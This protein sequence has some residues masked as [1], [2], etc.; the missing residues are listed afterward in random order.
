MH[1]SCT[2]NY[3][4]DIKSRENEYCPDDCSNGGDDDND[5]KFKKNIVSEYYVF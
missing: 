2:V 5:I 3:F 1:V 4:I